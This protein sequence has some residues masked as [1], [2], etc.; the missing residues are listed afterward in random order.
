MQRRLRA[1]VNRGDPGEASAA[2]LFALLWDSLADMLTTADSGR[3]AQQA[4]AHL[5]ERVENEEPP[6]V[7]IDSFKAIHD[8]LPG[9]ASGRSFVYD[10]SAA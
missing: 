6:L 5:V 4:P 1:D 3:G 9:A 2:E 10:L 7:A 8:L